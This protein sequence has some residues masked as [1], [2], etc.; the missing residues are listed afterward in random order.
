MCAGVRRQ[1]GPSLGR[2][3]DAVLSY[4][5]VIHVCDNHSARQVLTAPRGWRNCLCPCYGGLRTYSGN[6]LST[7]CVL[8]RRW[9]PQAA[10]CDGAMVTW[11]DWLVMRALDNEGAQRRRLTQPGGN[12]EGFLDKGCCSNYLNSEYQ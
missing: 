12:Q 1:F 3:T 2:L 4:L 11:C 9:R 8:A 10:P 6:V 7:Y 5:N